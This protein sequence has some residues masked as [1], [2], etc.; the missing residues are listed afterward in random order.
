MWLASASSPQLDCKPFSTFTDVIS[1]IHHTVLLKTKK[2]S[3]KALRNAKIASGPRL[4]TAISQSKRPILGGLFERPTLRLADWVTETSV[5]GGS[6]SMIDGLYVLNTLEFIGGLKI[7][8]RFQ[9]P[10]SGR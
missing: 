3:Q 10:S 7:G 5:K 9:V 1:D 4:C 2:D 8:F 6:S